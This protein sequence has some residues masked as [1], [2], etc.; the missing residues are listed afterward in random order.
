[1]SKMN[2]GQ[3]FLALVLFVG[4]IIILIGLTL[5]ILEASFVDT[6]YGYQASVQAEAAATSGAEDAL[7]QL[8]RNPGFTSNGYTVVVGS[9]TA[10]V[11]VANTAGIITIIATAEVSNRTKKVDVTAAVSTSTNQVAVT[12]WTVIQ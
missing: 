11:S 1:M 4:G 6:G 2:R 3:T 12:A 10:T 7:L 8:D 5:A 9:T